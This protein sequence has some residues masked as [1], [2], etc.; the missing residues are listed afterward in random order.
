MKLGILHARYALT[1]REGGGGSVTWFSTS[2]LHVAIEHP[3]MSQNRTV[4]L[5][6]LEQRRLP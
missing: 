4:H 3:V 6:V 2:I 5:A 1:A